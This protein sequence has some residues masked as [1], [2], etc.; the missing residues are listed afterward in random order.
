MKKIIDG[1]L[2][3]TETA[4][5]LGGYSNAGGWRDFAHFE[6]ALYQTKAGKFFLHGEGGPMSHYA[7]SSGQNSWGGGERIRP[8]SPEEAREWAEKRLDADRYMEIFGEPDE[9]A[10]EKT[11]LNLSVRAD[12]KTKLERLRSERG[13]SITSIIEALVDSI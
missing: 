5:R 8:M 3:N 9:A 6:E 4:R 10:D 13:Q 1:A 12:V 11:Q 7:V 2:Y